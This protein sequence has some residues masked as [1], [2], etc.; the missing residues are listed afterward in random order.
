MLK[1]KRRTIIEILKTIFETENTDDTNRVYVER[2]ARRLNASQKTIIKY[3]GALVELEILQRREK[4]YYLDICG[5]FRAYILIG[6]VNNNHKRF[7]AERSRILSKILDVAEKNAKK[8]LSIA[9]FLYSLGYLARSRI[10]EKIRLLSKI[11]TPNDLF[12]SEDRYTSLMDAICKKITGGLSLP[13]IFV[14]EP[15][16]EK[17]LFAELRR[18]LSIPAEDLMLKLELPIINSNTKIFE[19]TDNL[20]QIVE[21]ML[22]LLAIRA[23]RGRLPKYT[24]NEPLCVKQLIGWMEEALVLLSGTVISLIDIA[25]GA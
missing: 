13:K 5:A 24:R 23:F 20:K 19:I 15:W 11:Q 7:I 25:R 22:I 21:L 17:N 16:D 3:L 8:E 14:Q 9:E 12:G 6:L 1:V 4:A 18:V 10:Q 2:L